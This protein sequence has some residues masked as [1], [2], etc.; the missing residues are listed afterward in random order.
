MFMVTKQ[1]ITLGKQDELHE[2][3]RNRGKEALGLPT[4]MA[5]NSSLSLLTKNELKPL[6]FVLSARFLIFLFQLVSL[7][8]SPLITH[9]KPAPPYCKIPPFYKAKVATNLACKT[10]L[11]IGKEQ[12]KLLTELVNS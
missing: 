2:E 3:K 11:C 6:F 1:E 8:F 9:S 5:T 7:F 12:K 10:L 4:R